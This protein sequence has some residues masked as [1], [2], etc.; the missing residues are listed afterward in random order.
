MP[1]DRI[2]V[3]KEQVTLPPWPRPLYRRERGL[4]DC[5]QAASSGRHRGLAGPQRHAL[6]RPPSLRQLRAQTRERAQK[7][8]RSLRSPAKMR[9]W[10]RRSF[11]NMEISPPLVCPFR[12]FP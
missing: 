11:C 8:R 12:K 2:L 6:S 4:G 10:H 9:V 7:G 3:N 5:H 1:P